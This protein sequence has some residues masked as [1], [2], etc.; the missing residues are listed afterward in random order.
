[1]ENFDLGVCPGLSVLF[2]YAP[3]YRTWLF[4]NFIFE[5]ETFSYSF[6]ITYILLRQVISSKKMVMSSAKF[7]NLISWFPICTPLIPLSASMKLASTSVSII[8]IT[9][10]RGH[11]YQTPCIRVKVSKR[12]PFILFLNWMLVYA[13]LII[14]MNFSPYPTFAKQ[15][16]QNHNPL[17]QKLRGCYRE[18]KVEVYLAHQL[19][20]K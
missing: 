17:Y 14:Q 6:K 16:R 20:Q 1:M 3:A 11:P 10:E 18:K 15:K 19:R 4:E 5:L 8:Y 13:T 2:L 9:N 7:T 12:R